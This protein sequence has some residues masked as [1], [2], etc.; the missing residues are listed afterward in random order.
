MG[1][2]TGGFATGALGGVGFFLLIT[3]KGSGGGGGAPAGVADAFCLLFLLL[4]VAVDFL[5]GLILSNT[6]PGAGGVG[7]G[8]GVFCASALPAP[9]IKPKLNTNAKRRFF[10]T[11]CFLI[12][13][14]VGVNSAFYCNDEILGMFYTR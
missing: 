9:I 12:C 2:C 3:W 4:L 5:N 10:F 14:T 8:G 6:S 1:G 13:I 7:G 11:H